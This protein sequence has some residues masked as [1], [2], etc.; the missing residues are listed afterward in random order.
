MTIYIALGLIGLAGLCLLFFSL[1]GKRNQ[2]LRIRKLPQLTQLELAHN[3]NLETGNQLVFINGRGLG[4]DEHNISTVMSLPLL[5]W[6]SAQ[7]V[8]SDLPPMVMSGDGSLAQLS[9]MILSGAY[10]NAL[11]PNLLY[12]DY[13][14]TTGSGRF[15]YLA[16][17]LPEL[18]T[19]RVGMLVMAGGLSPEMC[20]LTDLSS[21]K[22][23]F[24]MAAS[25]CVAAQAVLLANTELALLGEEYYGIGMTPNHE[26]LPQPALRTQDVLR[27]V[28]IV[29]IVLAST[30]KAIGVF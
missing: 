26:G 15:S 19:D 7:T 14:H 13:S 29:T 5:R 27:I 1:H 25:D 4:A 10:Q 9:K 22:G 30:L 2:A 16:G 3:L 18:F 21:R 6:L 17:C 28:I 8:I 12:R 23:I 20:L 11:V 24:S